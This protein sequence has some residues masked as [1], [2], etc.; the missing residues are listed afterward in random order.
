MSEQWNK[1]YRNLPDEQRRKIV[2][3]SNDDARQRRKKNK[4]KAIQLK[5]GACEQ[6]GYKKC[7]RALDF[8]HKNR[9]RKVRICEVFQWQSWPRIAEELEKCVLLCANCHREVE[10]AL[11]EDTS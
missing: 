6:C 3:K 5:G 10:D 8:H 11:N 1:W 7:V 9:D 2:K 4:L